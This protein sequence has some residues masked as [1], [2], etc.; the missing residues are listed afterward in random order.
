MGVL[1]EIVV[2]FHLLSMAAIVGGWLAAG[3]QGRIV[4]SMLWGGRLAVVTG[5]ILV[6]IAEMIKTP[7]HMKIGVKFGIAL[8]VLGLGEI[9][10]SRQRKLAA[11]Q[12][13]LVGSVRCV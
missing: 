3:R 4:P 10:N 8:A 13:A 9:A 2:V 5:L 12:P 7:N 6:A 11:E 1:N